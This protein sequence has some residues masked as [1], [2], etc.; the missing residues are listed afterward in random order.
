MKRYFS[1]SSQPEMT[2]QAASSSQTRAL[3]IFPNMIEAL[4]VGLGGHGGG[5]RKARLRGARNVGR[6]A[7]FARPA[8]RLRLACGFG[9][10]FYHAHAAWRDL[11]P[12]QHGARH[13][14][15]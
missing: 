1:G 3:T 13:V 4:V 14:A 11:R 10:G 9:L 6:L 2:I 5:W 15:K 7:R 8:P 12:R